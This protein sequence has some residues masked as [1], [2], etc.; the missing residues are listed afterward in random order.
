MRTVLVLALF[1][2]MSDAG[3]KLPNGIELPAVWPPVVK[4]LT[5]EPMA[6][7]Y[8]QA[9]PAVL[10]I[11]LGRQLFV[12][13]FLIESSTLKRSYHQPKEH[14]RSPV[15]KPEAAWEFDDKDGG[16]AAPYSD[17]VWYDPAQKKF[18][19]WYRAG[20][21]RTCLATST[22]GLAWERPKFDIEP[23]TNV[24][25]KTIRD[26]TTVWLDPDAPPTERF[27]LFEARYKQRTWGQALHTSADGIHWTDEI[28][29]GGGS[30]DRTTAHFDPF[31]KKW[32]ASVRGHDT[33]KPDPVSRLRCY[34]ESAT[35]AGAV[36]WKQHC[37]D[38]AK[39]KLLPNDLVPWVRADRLDPRHPDAKYASLPPQL[40]NL[41][42]FPYESLMIGLFTMW[43]GPDN[44]TCKE[45]KIH[46]RNEVLAGFSR[47]G[48]HWHRPSR[49]RFLTVSDDPKRWNA[50]NVQSAGGGCVI[51]GDELWFYASGRTMHPQS[52]ASTGLFTL[53]RDGF[54]SMDAPAAGGIL[55]TRPVTFTGKH[56]FVNASPGT[57]TLRVEVLDAKGNVVSGFGRDQCAPITGDSTRSQVKWNDKD[58]PALAGQPV[59]FRF[60]LGAGSLWSFWVTDDANGASGGFVA[61][62]GP[63]YGGAQD[64]SKK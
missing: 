27:K 48:F 52:T 8:L 16:W 53:R 42:A 24:V 21:R 14:P 54:A 38:V 45:L 15:L 34:Y 32:V 41:D 5:T 28:A 20:N 59:R 11:D 47:D 18:L 51:V 62:G 9:I 55:T 7:P 12:D 4:H 64:R 10:P 23:G 33:N 35:A 36:Q 19:M 56:L 58:L 46:K 17:G 49:E 50:G 31:R 60:V 43:Q 29:V 26:S 2:S 57:G 30:W 44:E 6:V 61:A 40:Y 1:A 37:D 22:D 3:E 39:G 63:E 13:D 25:L